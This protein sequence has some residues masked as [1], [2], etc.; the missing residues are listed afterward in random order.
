MADITTNE[1]DAESRSVAIH[2]MIAV[3]G[4]PKV[5]IDEAVGIRYI[6][7]ASGEKFEFLIP[8]AKPG[9]PITMLALFGSKTK[10]TNETSRSRQRN[11]DSAA[12]LEALDEVFESIKNGVWREKAEGGGGSRTDK[13]VLAACLIEM[14]GTTA[15]GDVA[16]YVARFE[17][18]LPYMRKVLASD[19]GTKYREKMGKKGPAV[20]TLA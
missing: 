1:P 17:A 20:D 10:A 11:G 13:G 7:R 9:E 4:G 3:A 15:K 6:D 14:L 16:H 19:V 18:D 12:Q 2:E 8:N 5:G